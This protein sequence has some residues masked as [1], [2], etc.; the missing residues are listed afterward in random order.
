ML[1]ELTHP[2]N[3]HDLHTFDQLDILEIML[4]ELTKR[5]GGKQI[6]DE[7]H[8]GSVPFSD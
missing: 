7:G 8:T 3:S 1:L 2:E 5:N 6:N 4:S